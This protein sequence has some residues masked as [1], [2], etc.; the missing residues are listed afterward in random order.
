KI[1]ESFL[2]DIRRYVPLLHGHVDGGGVVADPGRHT[3]LHYEHDQSVTLRNI[4]VAVL[5][6]SARLVRLL[7]NDLFYLQ[8]GRYRVLFRTEQADTTYARKILEH[9]RR[10]VYQH[11]HPICVFAVFCDTLVYLP[12]Y[13]RASR[14]LRRT[15]GVPDILARGDRNGFI[16]DLFACGYTAC[17]SATNSIG[18]AVLQSVR[19]ARS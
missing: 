17:R 1:P 12:L 10:R 3:H 19:A 16:H 14:Y 9:D 11:L 2:E 8:Q 7:R 15:T 18:H 5:R 13:L 6:S 4:H